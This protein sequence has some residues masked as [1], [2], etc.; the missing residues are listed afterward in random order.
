MHVCLILHDN[1]YL[2]L[3]SILSGDEEDFGSDK[4]NVTFTDDELLQA[5]N[6]AEFSYERLK[7]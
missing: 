6:L 7:T 5:V 3:A 4:D 1:D 2:F